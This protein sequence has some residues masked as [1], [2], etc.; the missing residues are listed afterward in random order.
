MFTGL[1][2]LTRLSTN[3]TC[4]QEKTENSAL[5]WTAAEPS[6]GHRRDEH[7]RPRET[8]G[9]QLLRNVWYKMASSRQGHS[10]NKTVIEVRNRSCGSPETRFSNLFSQRFLMFSGA[11]DG[12]ENPPCAWES[13]SN[14][15]VSREIRTYLINPWLA[16]G[17]LLTNRRLGPTAGV[18]LSG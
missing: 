14:P 1:P 12:F 9:T 3:E 5:K 13:P 10:V 6:A 11:R 4:Q 8:A 16:S 7:L 2:R 15:G 17:V 18:W